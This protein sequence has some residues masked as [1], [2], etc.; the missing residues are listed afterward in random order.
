M[1]WGF[2]RF[3]LFLFLGLL[4]APTRNSPERVRDTIR[5]FPEKDGNPP[6]LKT[7]RFSLS[8]DLEA[9]WLQFAERSAISKSLRFRE[10]RTI[11]HYHPERKERESSEGN[12]GSNH[13]Y[14][15]YRHA[16]KT[17][18]KTIS[19]IAILWPV[20][21]IFDKRTASVEVDTFISPAIAILQFGHLSSP[22][23]P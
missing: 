23:K 21:A 16:G 14:G 5:T 1:F 13:L 20:K 2:S 18:S 12:S 9:V 7:P 15:R 8:Q 22:C 17:T 3:V 19:T 6:G 11:Y 10:L 4:T